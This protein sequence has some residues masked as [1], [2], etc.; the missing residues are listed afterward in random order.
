MTIQDWWQKVRALA[1]N[2]KNDG[3]QQVSSNRAKAYYFAR[4]VLFKD[5]RHTPINTHINSMNSYSCH[6]TF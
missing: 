4:E 3:Y 2:L 1:I 6:P 5:R